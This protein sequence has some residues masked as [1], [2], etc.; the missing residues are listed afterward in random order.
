MSNKEDHVIRGDSVPQK[1]GDV[2]GSGGGGEQYSETEALAQAARAWEELPDEI[3]ER[4]TQVR[5]FIRRGLSYTV[6]AS[7]LKVSTRTVK[8]DVAWLRHV[9]KYW[10][11]RFVN[12][13]EIG[14]SASLFI[15]I[16]N[17]SMRMAEDASR[18]FEFESKVKLVKA[19][20]DT[21]EET[22]ETKKIMVDHQAV[23]NHLRNA[24]QA[25]VQRQVMLRNANLMKTAAV[26]VNLGGQVNVG[27]LSDEQ[28][29]SVADENARRI[30][31]LSAAIA[32]LTTSKDRKSVV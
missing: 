23:S 12:E 32:R 22:T 4:R 27:V 13:E 1:S 2:D 30:A 9:G 19:A 20:D 25:R 21:L 7:F 29:R 8:R 31:E 10:V 28:L 11:E 5:D 17:I 6:I 18:P 15:E 14:E 16:E 3:A 24:M 26:N